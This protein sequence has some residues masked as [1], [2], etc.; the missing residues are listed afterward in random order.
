MGDTTWE[1]Q[2][3]IEPVTSHTRPHNFFIRLWEIPMKTNNVKEV[4]AIRT[5][6]AAIFG[7]YIL[8]VGQLVSAQTQGAQSAADASI[9]A[10]IVVSA[11]RREEPLSKVPVS[12]SAFSQDT[13]DK[14][15]VHNVQELVAFVPGL[16]AN[17]IDNT[18]SIRGI[19]ASAGPATT[20][21]YIND[22][23]IQFTN[24]GDITVGATPNIFDVQRVEVLRGPQGTLFG[25][26]AE[27]GAVRFILNQPS[28]TDFSSYFKSDGYSVQN[29][30]LGWELGAAAG[31]PIVKDA[32][33]FRVSANYRTN[34]GWIDRIDYNSGD[35]LAKNSNHGGQSS[36]RAAL[37]LAPAPGLTI[38]PSVLYQK[39]Y[40]HDGF[41]NQNAYSTY[42]SDPSNG[43]FAVNLPLGMPFEN[44]FWLPA[45]DVKWELPGAT[46]ISNTSNFDRHMAFKQ[47]YTLYLGGLFGAVTPQGLDVPGQPNYTAQGNEYNTQ[48]DF[49]QEFR[50]QSNDAE[51]RLRW[52]GGVFYSKIHQDYLEYL[53]DPMANQFTLAL[54]GATIEQLFGFPLAPPDISFGTHRH[55]DRK[56]AAAF[57]DFTWKFTDRLALDV[58]ARVAHESFTFSSLQYGPYG[59]GSATITDGTSDNPVT[60][61]V[62]L[63]YQ[64]DHNLFYATVAK[65]Y[66]SGG[67]NRPVPVPFCTSDLNKLGLSAA[68][69]TYDPDS[70]WS[71]EV[72]AKDNF[73]GGAL[74]VASSAYWINWKNIQT[75]IFLPTCGADFAANGGQ[76]RSRGVDVQADYRIGRDFTLGVSAGYN[77]AVYTKT[78]VSGPNSILVNS[79]DT[80]GT[81]L[82][83]AALNGTYRIN[84][85]A[86]TG[87]A[88]ADYLFSA[89]NKGMTPSTDP[90]TTSY[91]PGTILQPTTHTVNLRLGV[92]FNSWDISLY[93]TNLTNPHPILTNEPP[94]DS[95]YGYEYSQTTIL[96]RVI[97]VS[98]IVKY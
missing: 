84:F 74:Q 53:H 10:E 46:L 59:G 78:V 57:G 86:V 95:V 76:A 66:R 47:D 79:G 55:I 24:I 71:Y 45:L 6:A 15:D 87:Y 5:C 20:G 9:L 31:G 56:Q 82:W 83:T 26:G 2:R 40:S 58:G 39:V 89:A 43:H 38:T 91:L 61:K 13:L 96:P 72:G 73:L 77:N 32:M 52:L 18:I 98:A 97:G 30:G 92:Q 19:S 44:T 80:L 3:F 7:V 94:P 12:V 35:V 41:P 1:R 29:G 69:T 70:T 42:W 28:L 81:P 75:E 90:A 67:G 17:P 62:T 33:G 88:R 65:G 51:A 14:Q 8:L 34:A 85:N 16:Q 50:I 49:T 54:T 37:T 4:K 68:P 60:P 36:L 25:A 11:T 21:L 64:A 63:S 23:P 48:N 27:G 93:S 22:T